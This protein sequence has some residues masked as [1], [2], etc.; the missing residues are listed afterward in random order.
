MLL[1]QARFFAIVRKKCGGTA[2]KMRCRKAV[3]SDRRLRVE[4]TR[5]QSMDAP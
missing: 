2:M 5:W 4:S 3:T 1:V